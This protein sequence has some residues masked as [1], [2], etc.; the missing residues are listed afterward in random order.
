M[1]ESELEQESTEKDYRL[2]NFD[3]ELELCH[4]CGEEALNSRETLDGNFVES[5]CGACGIRTRD[6]I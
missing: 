1:A 5:I 3:G 4:E 6:Y 2:R